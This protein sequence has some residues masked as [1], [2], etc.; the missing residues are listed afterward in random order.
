MP[1]ITTPVTLGA[2]T[3]RV[4]LMVHDVGQM[5]TTIVMTLL[6]SEPPTPCGPH[7]LLLAGAAISARNAYL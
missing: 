5:I 7:V 2:V 1:V 6:P 3:S 4:Y